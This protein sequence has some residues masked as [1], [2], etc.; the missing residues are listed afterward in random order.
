MQKEQ[1]NLA[2]YQIRSLGYSGNEKYRSVLTLVSNKAASSKLKRHARKALIDL[3][4][5]IT[6]NKLIADTK[7]VSEGKSAEVTSYMKMLTVDEFFVQKLAARAIFHEQILDQDLLDLAAE[8]LKYLYLKE[9]LDGEWQ[10]TASWLCKAIG[11][12]GKPTY[13]D[14][15]STVAA[16]SPYR[17]IQKYARKYG[18]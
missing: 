4:Q 16:D 15:L 5:F 6:W 12:S 14:L 18:R 10:D 11:Q 7:V 17:K 13:L 8:N 9:G 1:L 2:S 3:D